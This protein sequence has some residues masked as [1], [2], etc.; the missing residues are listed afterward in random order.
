MNRLIGYAMRIAL[1]ILFSFIVVVFVW[2]QLWN[3]GFYTNE[4][5]NQATEFLRSLGVL[6]EIRRTPVMPI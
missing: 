3:H 2:D 5:V 4:I 6:K 1:I